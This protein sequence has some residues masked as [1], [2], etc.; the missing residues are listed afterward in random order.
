MANDAHKFLE[1]TLTVANGATI[2][3][4]MSL[5]PWTTF[6]GVSFPAM[7]DGACGVEYSRDTGST[8]VPIIDPADGADYVI[9]ASGSDP[10]HADISD[11][12][13]TVARGS[14]HHLIRFTC[15]AQTPAIEL[16][17]IEQS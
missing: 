16:V 13:R 14:V 3:S 9:A 15:A 1:T 8:Y 2:S 17:V 4:G 7:D 12:I 6:V 10:C 5:Q 11:F